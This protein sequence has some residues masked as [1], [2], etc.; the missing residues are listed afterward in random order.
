MNWEALTF[1][2]L[3]EFKQ[4]HGKLANVCKSKNQLSA[5]PIFSKS[6]FVHMF[7]F[8]KSLPTIKGDLQRHTS[9][10]YMALRLELVP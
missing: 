9:Q 3:A 8:Q 6:A 4:Q 5:I 10:H 1:V 7:F 2:Y